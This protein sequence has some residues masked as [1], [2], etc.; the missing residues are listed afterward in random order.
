MAYKIKVVLPGQTPV[1]TDPQWASVPPGEYVSFYFADGDLHPNV[2]VE[3][4]A[5]KERDNPEGHLLPT[6]HNGPFGN[7]V[8]L[9]TQIFGRVLDSPPHPTYYR[10]YYYVVKDGKRLQALTAADYIGG[11]DVPVMPPPGVPA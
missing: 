1:E 5:V 2:E 11:I 3:F 6:G 10:F 4:F 7:L 9:G 8:H